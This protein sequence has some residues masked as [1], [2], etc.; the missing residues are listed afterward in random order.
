MKKSF[1]IR[2]SAGFLALVVLLTYINISHLNTVFARGNGITLPELSNI[3]PISEVGNTQITVELS[4]NLNNPAFSLRYLFSQS[5]YEDI[6]NNFRVGYS[7]SGNGATRSITLRSDLV[8]G[9]WYLYVWAITRSEDGDNEYVLRDIVLH[10]FDI[11]D[12]S[13]IPLPSSDANLSDLRV[14]SINGT[15][16]QLNENNIFIA[17][18]EVSE[19]NME[20]VTNH[21]KAIIEGDGRH[22]LNIGYNDIKII[23]TA[24]DR[25]T[26][27]EYP[28]VIYR[29]E[30]VP[31]NHND[32]E[33]YFD[34][35]LEYLRVDSING[36][37]LPFEN[38]V[39]I[40]SY[41]ILEVDI[42][43]I[44]NHEK[45]TVEGYG[46]HYLEEGYN[47]IK[48]IVT[49]ENR[50]TTKEYLVVIYRKEEYPNN[51]N[52]NDNDNDYYSDT[53]LKDL[54][55]NG[56]SVLDWPSITFPY[57]ISSVIIVPTVNSE[58]ANIA[59]ISGP[60]VLSVGRNVFVIKVIAADG[61]T[62]QEHHVVVYREGIEVEYSSDARLRSVIANRSLLQYDTSA[63]VFSA[64]VPYKTYSVLIE[65][66][67]YCEYASVY[68]DGI[69][70]LTE[71]HN[72][73][74]ITITAEDG[75]TTSVHR[76]LIFRESALSSDANLINLTVNGSL[77]Y[78]DTNANLYLINVAHAVSNAQIMAVPNHQN[79]NVSGVGSHNLVVGNN[80]VIV[81]VVAEDR[82]TTKEYNI[83]IYRE[84]IVSSDA[85]L[86]SLTV[87]GALLYYDTNTGIRSINFSHEVNS[88]NIVATTNHPNATIF[89]DG[90]QALVQG[91][92][93]FVIIVTAE[94]RVTTREYHIG[95]YIEGEL[96]SDANLR[97]L[98]VNDGLLLWHNV[99][100][101][102]YSINLPHE[103]SF[104]NVDAI[105]NHPN[106]TVFGDGIHNLVIGNNSI[107][108]IVTAENGVNTKPY[109]IVIYRESELSSDARLRGLTVNGS[110]L[111]H[112]TITD[113]YSIV[114]PYEVS[115]ANIDA[116]TNHPNA[117]VLGHGV[118][119][120][121][122]GNTRFVITVTSENGM[123]RQDYVIVVNRSSA[124]SQ[125][126]RLS[127]LRA[128]NLLL[129]YDRDRNEYW[130]EA[131]YGTNTI[132]II[133]RTAHARATVEGTGVHSLG[134][135]RNTIT[136]TVIAED[137]TTSQNYTIV[138]FLN[139]QLSNNV[140][141]NNIRVRHF[142]ISYD[143]VNNVYLAEVPYE[144]SLV[145]IMAQ[146]SCNRA[147]LSGTGFQRLSVGDNHFPLTVTAENG[148]TAT[149]SLTITRKPLPDEPSSDSDPVTT[150]EQ[151]L[152]G[153]QPQNPNNTANPE[154]PNS[155]NQVQPQNP[156]ISVNPPPPGLPTMPTHPG[157]STP[158]P[159]VTSRP[160][161]NSPNMPTQNDPPPIT[162]VAGPRPAT[163]IGNTTLARTRLVEF[164]P[165][166]G[167][168][169][170]VVDVDEL[171]VTPE[172]WRQKFNEL[173]KDTGVIIGNIS[174]ICEIG[175]GRFTRLANIITEPGDYSLHFMIY[176]NAG[177]IL[178]NSREDGVFSFRISE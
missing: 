34:A 69:R 177:N 54:T 174:I 52:D 143:P 154:L 128:G 160:Q 12:D 145:E 110:L 50:I 150:P 168:T 63:S 66:L 157:G 136:L 8:I 47:N 26:A 170:I 156:G 58:G 127:E 76:I 6:R 98:T 4:N 161:G 155:N 61:I 116:I 175:T 132:E 111:H 108:I 35:S 113:V 95:V 78:H 107:I 41:E 167:N 126:T 151:G 84:G 80:S 83:V 142:M 134:V 85:R 100:D 172:Y 92:N 89:G 23:V 42:V 32:N 28:I 104:A 71:G 120:L 59:S 101:D 114:V 21:E 56:I 13:P 165:R 103:I 79:A 87:N 99:N 131:P 44:P 46:R 93:R 173:I 152:P 57:E 139:D 31:E 74:L 164:V 48:I 109:N 60:N 97:G 64:R 20:A 118:H 29:K 171:N 73:F 124:L 153:N 17:P 119:Y 106:A 67:T 37:P 45:A 18:Y 70:Y 90:I 129:F 133:A 159:G 141:I 40:A 9:T 7:L 2:F 138:V 53:S 55:V 68:G 11:Y 24:E 10:Q 176:N 75:V 169:S 33:Y 27:K 105:T 15:Q 137:R 146:T 122:E 112:D 94:D 162:P 96:S 86:I 3:Y 30:E 144:T 77:L 43:A 102:V 65:I 5:P 135:G 121:I 149:Y 82:V 19:V 140:Q 178:F 51:D 25:I 147:T 91:N 39:F 1:K 117:S 22:Y 166:F 130:I 115:S 16:L 158:I 163:P 125:D 81:T 88:A 38:N 49:A 123:V 62:S 14:Y 36:V 148:D 72:P